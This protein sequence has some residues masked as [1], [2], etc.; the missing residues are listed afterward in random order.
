M[1]GG[2]SA[3]IA[4]QDGNPVTCLQPNT[5]FDPVGVFSRCAPYFKSSPLA[6]IRAKAPAARITYVDGKD[7]AAAASAAASADVAIVFAT[8][9][10]SENMDLASLRLPSQSTDTAN[11]SYDQDALI[12][13]VAARNPSTVVVLEN[14]TAV[15]MP[16]LA[17]VSSVLAAWYPGVRGGQAIADVLFGDVNPSGKLPLTFPQREQDLPQK[18]I[19]QTELTI[20]YA[21]GL[22]IG[23]RWFDA[24]NIA[25][26]FPFGH[27]LSYTTF[28]Y[29]GLQV[30][31]QQSGDVLVKVT[32]K[33]DGTRTGA[34][35][36]QVYAE[37]PAG[38]DQPPKRLVAWQKVE[39]KPGEARQLIIPVPKQRFNVWNAS[40]RKA[41]VLSGI[42]Q[43]QVGGSSRS[44]AMLSGELRN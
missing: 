35:V 28:S 13:A 22:K 25:P 23:Y 6:A 18:T 19:P 14:G 27:G 16:W 30:S 36:A 10:T 9:F 34:E 31:K 8:Q 2:G 26:L 38:A 12:T 32:L 43:L 7:A 11:Q 4:P 41:E 20:N 29:S 17:N 44:P 39:L 24:N 5:S 1:H 15:T 42:Y 33:N 3:S 40:L 21:E 37:L